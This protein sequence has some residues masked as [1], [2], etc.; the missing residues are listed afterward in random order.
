[1]QDATVIKKLAE[2]NKSEIRRFSAYLQSPFFSWNPKTVSLGLYLLDLYPQFPPEPLKKEKLFELLFPSDRAYTDQLIHDQFSLLNKCLRQFMAQLQYEQDERQQQFYLAQAYVAQGKNS[3]FN[4]TFKRV[5]KKVSQASSRSP[6]DHLQL[7]AMYQEE[8]KLP[9]SRKVRK[10]G[11]PLIPMVDNLDRFYLT[12]KLKYACEMLNRQSIFNIQY[13]APLTET[14]IEFLAA[15]A[16]SY[17]QQPLISLYF[18]IY[19]LLQEPDDERYQALR[20][21][22]Y[23]HQEALPGEEKTNIYVFLQNHCI[24]QL[25]AGQ[26]RYLQE[27]FSLYQTLLE[28]KILYDKQGFIPHPYIKNMVTVGLRLQ[29]YD[30]VKH[31]LETY[32]DHIHPQQR[33]DAF[34]YNMAQYHY[35]RQQY[36]KALKLLIQI[37]YT[38]LFYQLDARMLQMRIYYEMEEDD[39]LNYLVKAFKTFLKR[40]Q[41]LSKKQYGPYENLLKFAHQAYRLKISQH[42]M[43]QEKRE[44]KLQQ[45]RARIA[46]AGGVANMHWLERKLGELEGNV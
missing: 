5:K 36:R 3:H 8:R 19:R 38:D 32:K 22:L 10:G 20:Q 23:K 4:Q 30:W 28:Q 2:F 7:F 37:Q 26:T 43:S 15:H 13:Q 34:H 33:E 45:L 46:A 21:Q 25:N 42:N 1:M 40:N 41:S 29:H 39:S 24:K 11:D 17:D 31:F 18:Q 14:L 12:H 9:A 35:E 27:L 44:A 16:A 6:E